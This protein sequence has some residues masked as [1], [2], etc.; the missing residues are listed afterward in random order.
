MSEDAPPRAV[1]DVW[2]VWVHEHTRAL[3]WL[4]VALAIPYLVL[5]NGLA[6]FIVSALL[7]GNCG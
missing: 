6:I 5:C 2:R 1:R 7:G 3:F 4:S